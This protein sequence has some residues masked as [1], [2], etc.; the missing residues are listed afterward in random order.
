ME[1]IDFKKQ[2]K[3]L[4]TASAKKI[5]D[6]IVPALKYLEIEGSGIPDVSPEFQLAI[7]TLYTITYSA[8]FGLKYDQFT[9]PKGYSDFSVAP[10]ESKWWTD[11]GEFSHDH[12]EEWHWRM[13]IAIPDFFDATLL[14]AVI[15]AAKLKKE[16]LPY[17]LIKIKTDKG[18][19]AIQL[20]HF[21]P[22]DTVGSSIE[23]LVEF[24][25]AEGTKQVGLHH[26]I[27]LNNPC[28]TAPEKIKTIV[29]FYYKP[30]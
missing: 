21:G 1:K 24:M 7:E 23:R 18:G 11:S 16:K 9:H 10:L 5:S 3:S 8:K 13:M 6:I 25:E 30:I 26:E 27:Y 2:Y 20:M 14:K 15:S 28:R 12:P 29:R 19:K 22:Y 17:H 4:Y